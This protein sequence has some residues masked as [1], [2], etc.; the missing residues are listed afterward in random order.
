[1]T[2]AKKAEPVAFEV[3]L[4]RLEAIVAELGDDGVPLDRALALFEEGLTQLKAASGELERAEATLKQLV[5]QADGSFDLT[6]V[7]SRTD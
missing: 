2:A 6:D 4:E 3:R 1:M 7:R 5:E